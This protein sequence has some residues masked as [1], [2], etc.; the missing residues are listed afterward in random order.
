[1]PFLMLSHAKIS[2]LVSSHFMTLTDKSLVICYIY[3]LHTDTMYNNTY[4]HVHIITYVHT[5]IFIHIQTYLC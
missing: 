1:M 2:F 3:T 4:V 5:Y